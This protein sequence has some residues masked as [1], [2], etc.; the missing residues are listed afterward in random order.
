TY[1]LTDT[2]TD[3]DT[4]TDTETVTDTR[5][6]TPTVTVT[7]T[8]TDT[9]TV[10]DT[11]TDTSTD[12]ATKTVTDTDTR[13]ATSTDTPTATPTRTDTVTLTDSPTATPTATV[14]DT[15][16]DTPSPTP[17]STPTLTSSDTATAS[18]TPTRTITRTDTRTA[19]A[20]NTGSVTD[21]RTSTAT[22]TASDTPTAS[23]TTSDTPTVTDSPTVTISPTEVLSQVVVTLQIFNSAG[24]LVRTLES[25][26]TVSAGTVGALVVSTGGT[27]MLGGGASVTIS[28]DGSSLSASWNG[29]NDNGQPVAS[30]DY[31]VLATIANPYGP[32]N[33]PPTT[34]STAVDVLISPEL[35]T[36]NIFNSAGELV[37]SQ[38]T[39]STALSASFTLNSDLLVLQPGALPNL[40]NKLEV[41]L[42]GVN[43]VTWN[44][45]N[46]RGTLVGP[47]TYQ[48]QVALESPGSGVSTAV[49]AVTVVV[50]P[51]ADVLAQAVLAPNPALSG[52]PLELFI[53]GTA[54]TLRARLFSLNA[55]LADVWNLTPGVQGGEL[56]LWPHRALAPGIYLLELELDGVGQVPKRRVLKLAVLP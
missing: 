26:D 27:L 34:E 36:V 35:S 51:G 30:G 48:V 29:L 19:T 20:T 24:E 56:T 28:M 25:G 4:V 18:D 55:D 13:T 8:P 37:W 22:P 7:D 49:K 46:T 3:T 9:D 54:G 38:A 32:G 14:T 15:R 6:D 39:T 16:T 12:T 45:E 41:Q 17:T 40:Q 33:T 31:Q 5:T 50:L 2:P 47:G 1:T 11:P 42:E 44:G 21:T 43:A 52:A 10:T 23:P 53:G